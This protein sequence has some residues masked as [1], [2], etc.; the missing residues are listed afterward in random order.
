M[1]DHYWMSGFECP[2][3]E[4]VHF[5]LLCTTNH[6]NASHHKSI[7]ICSMLDH[8]TIEKEE[9]LESTKKELFL[10]LEKQLHIA[11]NTAVPKYLIESL[12]KDI[13]DGFRQ[14]LELNQM[15]MLQSPQVTLY[16]E[17]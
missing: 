14:D 3:K 9:T 6:Y 7:N 4:E 8:L 16:K 13:Y 10:S 11:W 17:A 15:E 2:S 1:I 5:H 12:L